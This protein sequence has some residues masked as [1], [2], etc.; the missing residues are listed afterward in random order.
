MERMSESSSIWPTVELDPVRRMRI[1]VS[2]L[3]RAA[4][5]EQVLDAPFE[6]VWQV[7]GDLERGTPQWKKDVA[8]LTIL[9]R[10][11]DRLEVE[12]RSHFGL[13]LHLRT[14]LRPG[15]CVMQGQLFAVGMAATAEGQRT[16]F[17]HFQA[18]RLPGARLL[19]PLLGHRM[20]H[21]IETLE[22][23]SRAADQRKSRG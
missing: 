15:W 6:S 22:R 18:L 11:E 4:L 19:S 2:A 9:R 16:R 17:A 3:P 10:E 21:E 7:A 20:H 8:A 13:R 5:R 14:V 1:L 23:L 12:I